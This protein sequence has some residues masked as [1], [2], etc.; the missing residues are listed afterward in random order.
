[1]IGLEPLDLGIVIV[2]ETADRY[3]FVTQPDHAVLAGTF[4]DHWGNGD[5]EHPAPMPP[6]VMAAYLHDAGW[7]AYD[8][9]PHLDDG[10][11]PVDFRATPADVW[12]ELY[13]DGIETVIELNPFAGLLVSMHG[14][15]LRKRRY[16]LSPGW[17]ATP[18]RYEPFVERQEARQSRLLGELLDDGQPS[19]LGAAD[20]ELLSALHEAGRPPDGCRSTLWQAYQ[21]LQV[22]D[23]LSLAFCT[24]VSPPGYGTIE[25]VPRGSD[26]DDVELSIDSADGDAFVVEPYPF[27]HEPYEA[28]I[29]S[30]TVRKDAFE[31]AGDL[32]RAY[33]AADRELTTLTL[34]R[35]SS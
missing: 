13:D 23:T 6:L 16:G 29:P 12:I 34:H 19:Q 25:D 21:L 30:R 15:G 28:T 8:R 35:M 22:W 24:T 31:T 10:G 9:R 7:E 18:A 20:A 5:I 32:A 1:L 26:A 3:R 11:R 4:A 2:A 27:D 33:D 17:P 14:V